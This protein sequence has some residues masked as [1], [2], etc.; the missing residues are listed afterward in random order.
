[1]RW[2]VSDLPIGWVETKLGEVVNYGKT[3]KVEPKNIPANAWILELEDIEKDTSRLLQR[4]TFAQRDSKSTKNAFKKDDVLYGKLRPYLNKIIVADRDGF[5]TTEIIPIKPNEAIIGR[6]LFYW[7]KNP[8][9]L[10]HVNSVSYGLNMPRLGTKDGL[11]APLV[12]APLDEQKRIAEKLDSLLARVDSCQLHLERVPQILKRFRQSVLAVATSGRLTEDWRDEHTNLP[13]YRTVTLREVATG[14]NYG[15]SAKSQRSGNIPVLRMGNIQDGKLD[16]NDLVFTSDKDEI[17]KYK[18]VKGD[19]LFNRT[20][21][22]EWVGKTAV[23]KDEQ[24]AIYAGYLVRVKC[25]DELLP[26]FLNYCLNSPMGRDWRWRVKSDG[27]SQSN[28]N[29]QKLADFEFELPPVE[30]QTE[31]VRRVEK[32]FAYAERLEARYYSASEQ[33]ERLTPSL[34]AKAFRGELV[35]QDPNDE[36]AEGVMEKV[37]ARREDISPQK[38]G[39]RRERK[40]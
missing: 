15:T 32:L 36:S 28:I 16:W 37:K 30:E 25:G 14:F 23:Y 6:Y 5:C 27:V 19:V 40:G 7:L 21:S 10:N 13:K 20:N 35:E 18:L 4:L 17:E 12:L 38:T 34:L 1:M 3:E 26:D 31:I 22:P 11:A 33:V 39:P 2:A 9:F 8:E 24:P 29:A